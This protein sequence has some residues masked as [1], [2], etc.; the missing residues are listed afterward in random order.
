MA[1]RR[2][3]APDF[4][5]DQ[6]FEI[7]RQARVELARRYAAEKDILN[8]GRICFPDKFNMPFCH[9]LHDYF[10]EIRN[11]EFTSTE[12][13]RYHAKTTIKCFLIPIF[14]ALNEPE[15][16]RHYLNVQ[17]TLEK[18]IG[19][20]ISIG[21]ELEKNELLRELYGD[22][23]GDEKWTEKQFVLRNGVVFTAIG[24]GQSIRGINYRNQRPDY[25]IV[26]DLYNEEDIE[27]L[28]STRK[29]TSWF[30]GS[31]YHAM[32]QS[33]RSSLHVQGTAI[34]SE[35]ILEKTKTAKGVRQ[36]TFRAIK[37]HETKEVLWPEL[38]TYDELMA[39]LERGMPIVIFNRE[40]QNERRNDTESV[41]K[42]AWLSGWEYEPADMKL[43]ASFKVSAVI[44]GVD[45]SVGEK[46][47]NDFTGIALVIKT[48]K[49][50]EREPRFW[51]EGLWNEHLSFD[52]RVKKVQEI[53]DSRPKHLPITIANIE[54]I[55]AFKDT[56]L[57][58][59]SKTS[60]NV[61]IVDKVPDKITHLV[62]K[63]HHFQTGRVR[64]N[65]NI[66]QNLK[67]MIK[68]QLI[69]N[70]PPHDDLRDAVLQ[71]LDNKAS[72]WDAWK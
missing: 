5:A 65:R 41:I 4:S 11:D 31:L 37:N 67:D 23:I 50:D 9:E 13:P 53:A 38:K 19:I 10:V 45:P 64:L 34:N 8:W 35:D 46:L 63:S 58:I 20:N 18:A 62:N 15:T 6:L 71:A 60:V 14:Q 2:E 56:A 66:P 54:G 68:N 29:L 39:T 69:T 51:I 17:A 32:S 33:R 44:L 27:N 22:Q 59:K 26:D 72:T 36:R 40:M 43:D 3:A 24:A 7:R 25:V 55:G 28:D 70:K 12:A 1:K 61:K 48:K 52:E 21:L 47:V 49:V 57:A 16:F 30:W 42:E